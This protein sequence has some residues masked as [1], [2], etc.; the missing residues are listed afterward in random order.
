MLCLKLKIWTSQ[1]QSQWAQKF[2]LCQLLILHLE[3]LA[4]ILLSTE[5]NKGKDIAYMQ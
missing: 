2:R 3:I 5:K 1:L 4:S